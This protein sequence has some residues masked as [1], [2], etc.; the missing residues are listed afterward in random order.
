MITRADEALY[1]SKESG[2]DCGHFHDV[3]SIIP[4]NEPMRM[5]P[6]EPETAEVACAYE[7]GISTRKEFVVDVRRRLSEWQRGGTPLCLLFV[8]VDELDAIAERHG[9]E[10]YHAIRRALTLTLKAVMR[11]MDHVAR[12]DGQTLSL[13]LPGCTLRGAVGVAERLRQAVALCEMPERYPTRYFTVSVGVTEAVGDEDEA[14]L[15]FRAEQCLKAATEQG[16]NCTFVHDGQFCHLIGTG[17]V[18]MA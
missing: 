18:S 2:R 14:A 8:C 10:N 9:E 15:I 5:E 6:E 1:A 17:N 11:E 16:R 4:L 13:L 3:K 7:V 12:F